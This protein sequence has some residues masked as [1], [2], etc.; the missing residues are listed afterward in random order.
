ME[1]EI[2]FN[3]MPCAKG[4]IGEIVLNRPKALNALT[5]SMC[6]SIR[7]H[8]LAWQ[9]DDNI[10]IVVIRGEGER[11]FCAGGDIRQ[12]YEGGSQET[13]QAENFF[14]HEYEMNKA[15][16][17]FNKPY[18]ALL[19]G[20][21]MGGGVGVSVHGS[22]RVATERL[23]LAMPETGIGFFPDIGAGHFLNGCP[24]KLGYYLG[25]T[26]NKIG[27]DDALALGLATHAVPSQQLDILM[28]A[29]CQGD[30]D[31]N[32]YAVVDAVIQAFV[33][34]GGENELAA[35]KSIIDHCF[36]ESTV[37][38][39]IVRLEE[40]EL[41]WASDVVKTLLT[42]SPLS[43][44]VTLEQLRRAQ[45]MPFDTVMEME[46]HI[47]CHFMRASDFYEGVRA[48]LIDKDQSPRWDPPQLGEVREGRVHA[49]FN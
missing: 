33:N 13:E 28:G 48:A 34:V 30:Y 42:K 5:L 15:I 37:E 20:I 18:I 14:Y 26:G 9:D 21:T 31:S 3:L 43:L 6:C 4:L 7:E 46:Y 17:H 2:L 45:Q 12:L 39:I 8:L 1:K 16:F 29:L 11:A 24:G 40:Q 10:K 36:S 47:A 25:L 35:K 38:G 32:A 23:M 27:K 41:A 19:D 49:F 22:H 44:K